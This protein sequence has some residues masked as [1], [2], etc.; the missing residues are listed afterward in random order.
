MQNTGTPL[1]VKHSHPSTQL[2]TSAPLPFNFYC[3][4]E[5][6]YVADPASHLISTCDVTTDLF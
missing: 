2:Y 1:T 5:E 6:V 4:F 3:F